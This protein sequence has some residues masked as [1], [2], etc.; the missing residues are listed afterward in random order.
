VAAEILRAGRATAVAEEA[1][2][3][4]VRA[5]EEL[6]ADDVDIGIAAVSA[7]QSVGL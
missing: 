7:H 5:G 6:A 3:R 4:R 1:S 2:Q